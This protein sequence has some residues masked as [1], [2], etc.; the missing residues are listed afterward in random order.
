MPQAE[1]K[2]ALPLIAESV[3]ELKAMPVRALKQ[4]LTERGISVAGL[5]EKSDLVQAVDEQCRAI[6]YYA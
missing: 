6:T 1:P 3:E 4:L 2:K 5:S